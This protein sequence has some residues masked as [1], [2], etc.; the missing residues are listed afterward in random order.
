MSLPRVW[1]TWTA[2]VVLSIAGI[3]CDRDTAFNVAFENRVSSERQPT[4]ATTMIQLG[5]VRCF[6]LSNST[7]RPSY[8]PKGYSS[9]L[10]SHPVVDGEGVTWRC[11]SNDGQEF[12]KITIGTEAFELSKGRVFLLARED[13]KLKVR[14]VL[15]GPTNNSGS[16]LQ[17]L[18]ELERQHPEIL[19]IFQK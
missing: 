4:R 17:E 6:L 13:G 5:S 7:D 12:T 16:G 14:Q 18:N 8:T 9:C 15:T 1:V 11:E 2:T 19:E 3:G 10:G